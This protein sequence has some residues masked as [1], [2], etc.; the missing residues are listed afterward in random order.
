MNRKYEISEIAHPRYPWLHR[1]R[2][3]SDV[4]PGV[5]KGDLGGFVQSEENL[6]QD[7]TCWI[8]DE[9]IVCDDS[10][11]D[12]QAMVSGAAVVR[13]SALV[14][15]RAMIRQNAVIDD[16]AIVMAGFVRE[17]AHVAGNAAITASTVTGAW[18]HIEDHANVYGDVCGGVFVKGAA[19]VLPGV[20]IDNPTQDIFVVEQDRVTVERSYQRLHGIPQRPAKNQETKRKNRSEQ[21][22]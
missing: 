19:V 9:A 7:G 22:R 13:G 8:F 21:E 14:S 12:Q 18:P 6:S 17:S 10:F 2:A 1:I 5:Q 3:V 16:H 11:V 4:R 15:G 20:T